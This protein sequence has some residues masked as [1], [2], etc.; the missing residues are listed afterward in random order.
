VRISETDKQ[1][2]IAQY[3]SLAIVLLLIIVLALPVLLLRS[4]LDSM[5][6]KDAGWQQIDSVMALH[7]ELKHFKEDLDVDQHLKRVLQD[8][9]NAENLRQAFVD[10]NAT[11]ESGQIDSG[12]KN[13]SDRLAARLTGLGY[14]QPL[15]I[16]LANRELR[17]I[18]HDF[19]Q[20]F[21]SAKDSPQT[22]AEFICIAMLHSKAD[23]LSEVMEKRKEELLKKNSGGTLASDSYD[24][25]IA[26]QKRI[27]SSYDGSLPS[28]GMVA[29][30]FSDIYNFQSVLFYS[31]LYEQNSEING[32]LAIG[33]LEDSIKMQFLLKKALAS[34]RNAGIRRFV[35]RQDE[36]SE[37]QTP[38]GQKL[39]AK[40]PWF[41]FE[42]QKMQNNA[43]RSDELHIGVELHSSGQSK[44][45]TYQKAIRFTSGMLVLFGFATLVNVGLMRRK[46]PISLRQK[47]ILILALALFIPG[48]LVAILVYGIAGHVSASRADLAQS[49]LTTSLDQLEISY[50]E[51]ANRQMLANLRFKLAMTELLQ[52]SSPEQ[53]SVDVFSGYLF[54]NFSRS[55]IYDL[56]GRFFSLLFGERI[57]KLDRILQTNIVRFLNNAVGLRS[58]QLTR[59]HIDE[60]AYT[61]G[62]VDSL[63]KADFFRNEIS[64]ESENI[65]SLQNV[66][67]FSREHYYFFPDLST[68]ELKP[69]AIGFFRIAPD[70]MFELY[71]QSRKD[72]PHHFFSRSGDGYQTDLAIARTNPEYIVKEF[73]LDLS[74]RKPESLQ[75]LM[76]RAKQTGSS[77]NAG[78]KE[79]DTLTAWR[80][81]DSWPLIFVGSVKL[82]ASTFAAFYL[83]TFPYVLLVFTV[84]VLL[85]FSEVLSRFFLSPLDAV[86]K[87]MHAIAQEGELQFRVE[88]NNN[89]EFDKV[90]DAFNDMVAGLL[91][92]RHIS[93]F[94]S[95]SLINNI[96]HNTR[97]QNEGAGFMAILASDIRG[98]TSLSEMH[99]PEDIVSLLN[100][101]FTTM[102]AEIQSEGGII[103]RFIGDAIIAVFSGTG[104]ADTSARACRAAGK[105][106]SRLAE[107]NLKQKSL[108]KL[109][110]ENGIGVA[111]GQVESADI[112]QSG[113]RRD[114]MFF[115]EPVDLA[116][117]LE[118]ASK[119]GIHTR[120]II[121]K[122]TASL[123]EQA[124]LLRSMN[125]DETGECFEIVAEKEQNESF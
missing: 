95:S 28:P 58:N 62:F 77:G 59:K 79:T 101:Y 85:I 64:N 23:S 117:G 63:M 107:F 118:A 9:T 109:C 97:S 96:G 112:G 88:I 57:Y 69:K 92:K 53:I 83:Q 89:D 81:N 5:A 26:L 61:D 60:L 71:V 46:L 90:G 108:G 104:D 121:D 106:R 105:M 19:S 49:Q 7:E 103:Y 2:F 4:K 36:F 86:M 99:P 110:I 13:L 37:N 122:I 123:V 120:I 93:R 56:D 27:I 22:A 65:P 102:E 39:F 54:R 45:A 6:Q 43:G 10:L 44:V 52:E 24:N 18:S 11:G 14:P 76:H 3:S 114:F 55:T 67:P 33:Y 38:T 80:F 124:F 40:V 94:V 15:F 17:H 50:H 25:Y 1:S 111:S 34:P 78:G 72:F 68:P 47:I 48:I 125:A 16:V 98:F 66:N 113:S 30:F 91:Q 41:D 115:G 119:T 20:Q 73:L 12:L 82:Q 84:L 31:D 8:I 74:S 100:D 29:R 35:A 87:G 42:Q 21:S 116:E 32:L 75:P 70:E 51:T